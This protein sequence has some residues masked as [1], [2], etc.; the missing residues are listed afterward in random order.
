MSRGLGFGISRWI[1][2]VVFFRGGSRLY[3]LDFCHWLVI[4]FGLTEDNDFMILRINQAAFSE[5][6]A[7]LHA[8]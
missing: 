4:F 8:A 6:I 1:I 2:D 3:T 5:L 7:K